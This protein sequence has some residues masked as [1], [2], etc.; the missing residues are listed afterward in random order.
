M[1]VTAAFCF[2]KSQPQMIPMHKFVCSF[3]FSF[4]PFL[5]SLDR[6]Q[7]I[8]THLHLKDLISGQ[9]IS[10][11]EWIKHELIR[12]QNDIR[13]RHCQ[14][15]SELV[16]M[17]E[18]P[19]RFE[20]YKASVTGPALSYKRKSIMS[21]Y[22]LQ[23]HNIE[24]VRKRL[25]A[26]KRQ[27]SSVLLCRAFL[28]LWQHYRCASSPRQLLY[29]FDKMRVDMKLQKPVHPF[30]FKAKL[31]TILLGKVKLTEKLVKPWQ[32]I[33]EWVTTATVDD[34]NEQEGAQW[35]QLSISIFI[36]AK[37]LYTKGLSPP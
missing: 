10:P 26:D 15:Y 7:L 28:G 19:F 24:Q 14:S 21:Y 6:K 34:M 5:M 9:A 11:N 4:C 12:I 1:C 3:F 22:I 2:Y 18:E 36:I 32:W 37:K 13:P 31:M 35:I 25:V 30:H 20:A 23:L 29:E 8:S 17:I 16:Q 27:P 33:C